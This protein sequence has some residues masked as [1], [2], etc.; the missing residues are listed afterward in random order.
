M[1]NKGNGEILK[2]RNSL[3][4]EGYPKIKIGQFWSQKINQDKIINIL[5]FEELKNLP[6]KADLFKSL[7]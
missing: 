1:L 6:K 2:K 3:A 5:F 7:F 4:F